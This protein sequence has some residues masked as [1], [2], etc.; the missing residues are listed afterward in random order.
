MIRTTP[1]PSMGSVDVGIAQGFK[2][3]GIVTVRDLKRSLTT[4]SRS[5][6]IYRI[7]GRTHQASAAGEAPAKITGALADSAGYE[8]G[9]KMLTIGEGA[10]YAAYLENGTGHMAAR[11]HLKPAVERNAAQIGLL[12]GQNVLK[13][14]IK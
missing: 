14:M 5:G 1:L 2:K 9:N 6:R 10:K 11:P 12:I 7:G 4:G 3:G 8:V 13:R